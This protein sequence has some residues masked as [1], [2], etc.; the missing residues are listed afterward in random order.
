MFTFMI[1]ELKGPDLLLAERTLIFALHPHLDALVVEVVLDVA[2]QR[3]HQRV[4]VELN[5]T[6]RAR[7]LPLQ[8]RW[9]AAVSDLG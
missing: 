2:V 5:Q 9:H 4:I 7:W 8:H 1:L 3:R 6:N